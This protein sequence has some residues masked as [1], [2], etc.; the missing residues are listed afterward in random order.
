MS[1]KTKEEVILEG[2]DVGW[3]GRIL[4]VTLID[5]NGDGSNLDIHRQSG[6]QFD[7]H[8]AEAEKILAKRGLM[9]DPTDKWM[10]GSTGGYRR[11]IKK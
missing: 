6:T 9:I 4:R 2:S 10:W 1:D 8:I 11:V 5:Y 3:P 7:E